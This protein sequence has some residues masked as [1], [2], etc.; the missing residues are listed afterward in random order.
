MKE[1]NERLALTVGLLRGVLLVAAGLIAIFFPAL[2]LQFAA[3]AGGCLLIVDGIL[4]GFIG[5]AHG[6]ESPWPFWLGVTR[7]TLVIAAGLALV[8]S[9]FLAAMIDP[10]KLAMAVGIGA[11]GVGAIELIVL[12]WFRQDFP[13]TW[14]TWLGAVLYMALGLTLI[15]LPFEGALLAL[16]LGA[17][18]VAVFGAVQVWKAWSAATASR[19]FSRP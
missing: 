19:S 12:F 17:A 18:I 15:L 10:A 14:F 3:I 1:T 2:A 13:G 7:T 9:P 6:V 16:Q 11:L 4:G 5:R 8:F